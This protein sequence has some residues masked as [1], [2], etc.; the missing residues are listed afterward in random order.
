VALAF[1]SPAGAQE[2]EQGTW[3]GEMYPPGGLGVEV[4]YRVSQT[5]GALSIVMNNVELGD[6]PLSEPRLDGDRLTFWWEPGT[7]VDCTLQRQADRSF[8]GAC[9]AGN[10]EGSVIMRPPTS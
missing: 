1:A 4:T 9:A 7:R 8:T 10:G 5:N 3:T 6:M 2:L